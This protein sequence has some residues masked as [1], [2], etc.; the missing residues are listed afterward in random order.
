MVALLILVCDLGMQATPSPS[1][2]R[3]ELV[4]QP[5]YFTS[6][7]FVHPL[8]DDILRLIQIYHEQYLQ[9]QPKQPFVLFKSIWCSLGW[10]W[11]HFKV[12][13]ARAR[14]S[15]LQVTARLFL[16]VYIVIQRDSGLDESML[17]RMVMTEPPLSRVV[18]LF[19]FYTFFSS[20]PTPS[21]HSLHSITHV[22]I[23]IGAYSRLSV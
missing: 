21:A 2:T 23:P 22:P 19:G 18:A 15:F 17:E 4:L 6:S 3:G 13:D 8:R 1:A 12:F 14:E 9:T 10:N 5:S 20:Q 16:G 11:L 7:L